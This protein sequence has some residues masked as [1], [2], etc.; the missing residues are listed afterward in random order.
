MAY[1]LI[2]C[3]HSHCLAQA[4]Q[5]KCYAGGSAVGA[6]GGHA[7]QM[8]MLYPGWDGFPFEQPVKLPDGWEWIRTTKVV[9][10]AVVGLSQRRFWK[11]PQIVGVTSDGPLPENHPDQYVL[12]RL[13]QLADP[14]G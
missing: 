7:E 10:W 14:R 3:A 13:G 11:V 5:L 12:Y 1:E 6:C 9:R 4:T 8:S 2:Y